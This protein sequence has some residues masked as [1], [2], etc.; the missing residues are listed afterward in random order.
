[1]S[2]TGAQ[3]AHVLILHAGSSQHSRSF[4]HPQLRLWEDAKLTAGL[5]MVKDRMKLQA[6]LKGWVKRNLGDKVKQLRSLAQQHQQQQQEPPPQ[7]Q[8]QQEQQHVA[9]AVGSAAAAAVA[10][11]RGAQAPHTRT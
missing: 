3:L 5:Q 7:Q 9:G 6:F 1:L 10:A 11:A 2:C 8:P 4:N